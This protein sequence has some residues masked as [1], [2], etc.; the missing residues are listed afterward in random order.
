MKS[1]I[2]DDDNLKTLKIIQKFNLYRKTSRNYTSCLQLKFAYERTLL[3]LLKKKKNG[4]FFTY[5]SD[6]SYNENLFLTHK[7]R[8]NEKYSQRFRID[9]VHTYRTYQRW[10]QSYAASIYT[11]LYVF[12]VRRAWSFSLSYISLWC[13][14]ALCVCMC[15]EC[16]YVRPMKRTGALFFLSLS[17]W[18]QRR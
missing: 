4:N 7:T 1:S 5:S 11:T 10:L 3:K 17:G 9:N 2:I 6:L 18:A 16:I 14:N 12:F 8:S 13:V 15:A